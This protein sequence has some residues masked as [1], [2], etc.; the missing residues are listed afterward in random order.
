VTD[1]P[2]VVLENEGVNAVELLFETIE[3]GENKRISIITAIQNSLNLCPVESREIVKENVILIHGASL[4]KN[5]SIRLSNE[6][7]NLKAH[8][9]PIDGIWRGAQEIGII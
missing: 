8:T 1:Q 3:E 5:L 4:I 7:D 2:A 9:I 6:I